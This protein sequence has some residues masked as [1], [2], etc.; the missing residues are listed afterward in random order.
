MIYCRTCSNS[1]FNTSTLRRHECHGIAEGLANR[2]PAAKRTRLNRAT[3]PNESWSVQQPPALRGVSAR[4]VR[5]CS[6][7]VTAGRP[8]IARGRRHYAAP[9]MAGTYHRAGPA[10]QSA[11]SGR[12]RS[13]GTA[14]RRGAGR[15]GQFK[16]HFQQLRACY[17]VNVQWLDSV[18]PDPAFR[19]RSI[20]NGRSS[21]VYSTHGPVKY[22]RS[23]KRAVSPNKGIN[24]TG[25][26]LILV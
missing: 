1:L 8:K 14:A 23:V 3:P 7:G 13:D 15:T 5:V 11:R 24:G 4:R 26:I 2:L 19:M 21:D 10:A 22:E 25:V 6:P 18:G 12:N 16:L 17:D 9:A 20:T